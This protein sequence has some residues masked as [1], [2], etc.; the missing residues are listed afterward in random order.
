MLL[1]FISDFYSCN[2]EHVKIKY[3]CGRC[4]KGYDILEMP[5]K[6]MRLFQFAN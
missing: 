5:V 3:K 4:L 6:Y 2:N 1:Q